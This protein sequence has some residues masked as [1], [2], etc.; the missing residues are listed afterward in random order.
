MRKR[1]KYRPKRKP[2][3]LPQIAKALPEAG[4]KPEDYREDGLVEPLVRAIE[5]AHGIKG[6]A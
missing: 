3:T 5:A 4:L 2:L 6:D 1:S